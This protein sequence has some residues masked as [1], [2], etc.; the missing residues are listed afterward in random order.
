MKY[1]VIGGTLTVTP[2]VI[3]S[4]DVIWYDKDGGTSGTEFTYKYDGN[5]HVPVA[6]YA[7]DANVTLTVSGAQSLAGDRYTA[8]VTG[9]GGANGANY[10]LP[11]VDLGYSYR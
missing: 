2:K 9:I 6:V 1:A 7:A 10:E 8:T 4:S 5:A 3:D 11:V